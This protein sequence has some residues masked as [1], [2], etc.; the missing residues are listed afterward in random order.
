MRKTW[1]RRLLHRTSP[2]A[3]NGH[4]WLERR[5]VVSARPHFDLGDLLVGIE[6]HFV[7]CPSVHS[8]LFVLTTHHTH[9]FILLFIFIL[10]YASLLLLQRTPPTRRC[11]LRTEAGVE[12]SRTSSCHIQ[13]GI[14]RGCT[15]SLPALWLDPRQNLLHYLARS[16]AHSRIIN[17]YHHTIVQHWIE[18]CR[19]ICFQNIRQH[20]FS[21]SA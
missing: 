3:A 18:A 21:I 1:P 15:L 13:I 5:H 14:L 20:L 17:S 12:L 2:L 4:S 10:V 9:T 6:R 19:L 8:I 11:S 7:L 16:F